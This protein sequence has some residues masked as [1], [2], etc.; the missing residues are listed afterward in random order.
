[1]CSSLLLL[2]CRDNVV[3]ENEVSDRYIDDS[4]L[5]AQVG[6][7]R[8]TEATLQRHLVDLSPLTRA[9]YQNPERR[10]EL[11]DT[12]IRFELLA[13]EAKRRGHTQHPDVQLAYKQAMV[14]E[15]LRAEVRE[16]I[17][18]SDITDDEI[19]Q[20]YQEHLDDYQRPALVRAAHVL[21]KSEAEATAAL[22]VLMLKI[23]VDPKKARV[24]FGDLAS[25]SSLDT[26]T[27]ARR[28]DLQYFTQSG[29]LHGERRFPQSA[30]PPEVASV[31]FQLDK[32]GDIT[33]APIRSERGWHL[34]QRTGG[35]R[36]FER[37]F[38][39][40]KPEIR[41]LLF[42][43]RKAK[44]LEDYVKRL[45]SKAKI[46]I[47]EEAL[48]KLKLPTERSPQPSLRS[49]PRPPAGFPH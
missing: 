30:P 31:A 15:L 37:S 38:A 32:V 49:P 44:A 40:V 16:L 47:N 2:A 28:G 18:M 23:N 10:Q 45:R 46:S 35:K 17:K 48:Q 13:T 24:L 27:K 29:A 19:T 22:K 25:Q 8:I 1:M 39:E 20:Y 33:A 3:V 21:F 5:I 36:A 11:V 6:A 26:E 9:R 12:L 43:T 4:P 34:I 42:K 41:N 7:V 14:R